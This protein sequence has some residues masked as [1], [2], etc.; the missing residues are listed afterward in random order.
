VKLGVPAWERRRRQKVRLDVSM[1]LDLRRAAKSDSVKDTVDYWDV[2]KRAR[3]AAES[4][5]FR[6]AERLADRVAG[7]VLE[8][9][10]RILAAIV[11]VHKR[12][13]VMPRTQEAVVEIRRAR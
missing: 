10:R 2:E 8:S 4:G 7:I 1:E 12:P 5:E 9:D 6:L 13:A 3:A 11:A